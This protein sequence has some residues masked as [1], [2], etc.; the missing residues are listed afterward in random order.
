MGFIKTGTARYESTYVHLW[1]D[2]CIANC[3]A[4]WKCVHRLLP[5]GTEVIVVKS[6]P[7]ERV[8]TRL[9]LGANTSRDQFYSIRTLVLSQGE[10][11]LEVPEASILNYE[12]GWVIR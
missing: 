2:R 9:E 8:A 11:I 1:V 4:E 3:K 7:S 6:K 10:V 12:Q 5:E